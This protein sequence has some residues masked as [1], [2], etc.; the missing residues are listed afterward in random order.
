MYKFT[1]WHIQHLSISTIM[2]VPSDWTL[3]FSE[4][5]IHLGQATLRKKSP[6]HSRNVWYSNF[7]SHHMFKIVS[8]NLLW[9]CNDLCHYLMTCPQSC[10]WY[11]IYIKWSRDS[12]VGIMTGYRLDSLGSIPNSARLFLFSSVQTDSGAHTASYPMGTGGS[13]PKGKSGRGL[14]LTTHL[15]LVPRSKNMELQLHSPIRL[16]GN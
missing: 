12:S 15:R 14:K 9:W 16:H 11:N 3:P 1:Y 10:F 6:V 4:K 7:A 8:G 2:P 5:T 13:F